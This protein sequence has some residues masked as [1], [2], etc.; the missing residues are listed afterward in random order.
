MA[1]YEM[2]IIDLLDC[3]VQEEAGLER[4]NINLWHNPF[5]Y[6]SSACERGFIYFLRVRDRQRLRQLY[7]RAEKNPTNNSK[8]FL[9]A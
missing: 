5:L 3:V 1:P 2:P 7:Q 9:M 4:E 8:K 6:S